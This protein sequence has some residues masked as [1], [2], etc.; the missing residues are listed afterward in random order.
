MVCRLLMVFTPD[1]QFYLLEVLNREPPKDAKIKVY[2]KSGLMGTP[3][4]VSV[5]PGMSF[6][7]VYAKV[8]EDVKHFAKNPDE[9]S[10]DKY[11]FDLQICD[12]SGVASGA[13]YYPCHQRTI[14]PSMMRRW[15]YGK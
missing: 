2:G 5:S 8:W 10:A 4:L 12:C 1:I 7:A 14:Q 6:K 9:W 3:G 13:C 11:P 15:N